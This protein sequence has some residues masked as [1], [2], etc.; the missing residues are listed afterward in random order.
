M[1]GML[2]LISSDVSVI[3]RSITVDDLIRWGLY[4]CWLGVL[5]FPLKRIDRTDSWTALTYML[6]ICAYAAVFLIA[7]PASSSG[8]DYSP[9]K[10][11]IIVC[12]AAAAAAVRWF[13]NIEEKVTQTI[14]V[15]GKEIRNGDTGNDSKEQRK[16]G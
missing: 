1:E 7:M 10:S 9:A 5:L 2:S 12:C 11:L 15:M 13:I 8:L 3:L 16:A 6:V 14:I 4:L